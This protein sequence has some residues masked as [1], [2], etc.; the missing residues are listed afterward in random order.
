MLLDALLHIKD[1]IRSGF[2]HAR[3]SDDDADTIATTPETSTT[4]AGPH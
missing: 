3:D 2:R 1:Y 4:S